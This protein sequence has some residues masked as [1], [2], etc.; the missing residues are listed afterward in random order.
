MFFIKKS[1]WDKIPANHKSTD[2]YH[3]GTKL[4][5]ARYIDPSRPN[6]DQLMIEHRDFE[7]IPDNQPLT[8]YAIWQDGKVIGHCDM[9]NS[10]RRKHNQSGYATCYIGN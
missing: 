2:Q 6:S 8:R 10:G 3:T 7:I 4:C 9:T 5:S 1:Q